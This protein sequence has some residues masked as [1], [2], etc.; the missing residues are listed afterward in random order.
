MNI[1]NFENHINKTIVD[2]GYFYY[3]EGNVVEAYEQG[4]NEYIFHIEGSDEYEVIVEI[5][6]N[7]DILNSECDCPYDFGPV[8]KHEVAAYF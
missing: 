8:C 7:G 6:E 3:I 1:H 2:R 5:G 4:E